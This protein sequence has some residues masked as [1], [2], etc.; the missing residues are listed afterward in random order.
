MFC[1]QKESWNT[2]PPPTVFEEIMSMT[3]YQLLSQ[4]SINKARE[5]IKG[6]TSMSMMK[7]TL[8]ENGRDV[9][10]I[11]KEDSDKKGWL[12]RPVLPIRTSAWNRYFKNDQ[13]AFKPQRIVV[14]PQ[15]LEVLYSFSSLNSYVKCTYFH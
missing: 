3:D 2:T 6:I 9:H 4:A 7:M 11:Y 5:D 1:L 8:A 10:M 13:T 14:D 12:P 15:P